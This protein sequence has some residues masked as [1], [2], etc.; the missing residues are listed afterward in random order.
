MHRLYIHTHLLLYLPPLGELVLPSS[1]WC[2]CS[3]AATSEPSSP[4]SSRFAA[5]W[6]W[7]CWPS[8]LELSSSTFPQSDLLP[9]LNS[10]YIMY[11][12]LTK[13]SFGYI[14]YYNCESVLLSNKAFHI[15][16]I[17][18]RCCISHLNDLRLSDNEKYSKLYCITNKYCPAPLVT[19]R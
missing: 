4:P 3:C 19:T 1:A 14:F 5:A 11:I 2:C 15:A 18:H 13:I 9:F 16:N 10:L 17:R 8:S 7:P 6:H 12:K